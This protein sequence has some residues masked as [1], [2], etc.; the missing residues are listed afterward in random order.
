MF[1]PIALFA[2]IAPLEFGVVDTNASSEGCNPGS[3]F[4]TSG[5]Y[6][7][8]LLKSIASLT[9]AIS[10]LAFIVIVAATPEPSH[11]A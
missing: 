3:L 7:E 6:N 2:E 1:G 4:K 5:P 9:F 11:T 10:V 8:T